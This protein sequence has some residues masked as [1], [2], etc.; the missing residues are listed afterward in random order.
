MQKKIVFI[1][2]NPLSGMGGIASAVNNGIKILNKNNY[3]NDLL[4]SHEPNV[5]LLHSLLL[6]FKVIFCI[7]KYDANAVVY[8]LH[9]GP[10]GSLIRK[11]TFILVIKIKRGT[12]VTQYHSPIFYDYLKMCGF[13]FLILKCIAILSDKNLALNDYWRRIFSATLRNNFYVLSN[14]IFDRPLKKKYLR[15]KNV[16]NVSCVARLVREKNVQEVIKLAELDTRLMLS[17]AGDGSFKK[18]IED[19]SEKS[20][21]AKRIKLFGWITNN[22]A[23]DFISKSDIFILPSKYDSFGMV[24]LEALCT[25]TPVI[26]PKIRPVV[27]T[28]KNII[29][30]KHANDAQEIFSGIDDL[31]HIPPEKIRR[32]LLMKYGEKIYFNKINEIFSC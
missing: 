18:N 23:I 11:L 29:G 3:P 9:I 17:V 8:Y 4:I 25:G 10:K 1:S 22:E 13:W 24:Y 5:K 14:P 12:V 27:E 7:L 15:E 20:S 28:L 31:L 19:I 32:S 21:A 26:A 2:T 16:I 30:V 6:F